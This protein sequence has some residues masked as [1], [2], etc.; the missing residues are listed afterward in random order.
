MVPF[1]CRYGPTTT[2][3]RIGN[4]ELAFAL[5]LRLGL[6]V[7]PGHHDPFAYR[8]LADNRS[9]R[10]HSRRRGL[11]AAWRQVFLEAVGQVPRIIVPGLGV[12][13]GAPLVCDVTCVTVVTAK[14]AAWPGCLMRTVVWSS[15]RSRKTPPPTVKYKL[16]AL[17]VYA[18]SEWRCLGDGVTIRYG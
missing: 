5:R 7:L 14:G 16:P 1:G 17:V 9:L 18:V 3:L 10:L 15:G 2:Q 6:P 13:S 12:A 11:I 4:S 8:R